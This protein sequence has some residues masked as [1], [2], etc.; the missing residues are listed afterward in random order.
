MFHLRERASG[1]GDGQ[2][3]WL[4]RRFGGGAREGRGKHTEPEVESRWHALFLNR[5]FAIGRAH[6]EAGKPG[7]CIDLLELVQAAD[8]C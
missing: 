1:Y 6:T 3:G 5:L 2:T 7:G 4:Y 8:G